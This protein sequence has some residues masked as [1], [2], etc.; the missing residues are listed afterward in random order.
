MILL[1]HLFHTILRGGGI[2][3]SNKPF[4]FHFL[5][6]KGYEEQNTFQEQVILEN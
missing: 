3:Y 2:K 6:V 4:S 1:A 5:A